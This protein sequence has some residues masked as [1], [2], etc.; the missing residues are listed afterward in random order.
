MTRALV[1]GGTGFVG[2]NL[3][4]TLLRRGD[5]VHLAVRPGHA[6]WRLDGIEKSVAFHDADLRDPDAIS[7]V[8]A[9][10]RPEWV[11]HLATYGAYPDQDDLRTA[12]EV[13]TVGTLNLLEACAAIGFEAFVNTGSSSEYGF[14]DHA[15]T[16]AEALEPNSHYAVSKAMATLVCTHLARARS[17]P[18]TTLRLYSVYGPYEEPGRFIPALVLHGLQASLP[19]LADP[20]T[21]RD[22]VHVEDACNAYLAAA[23]ASPR[24][25]A[26]YNVGSGVQTTLADAVSIAT[27]V[28]GIEERPVWGSLGAR[29]WDTSVWVADA[30]LIRDALGWT[31]TRKF[32]QGLRETAE[33]FRAN[34]ELQAFYRKRLRAPLISSAAGADLR[35]P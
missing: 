23:A 12:L 16:E 34:P 6:R 19:P 9:E 2:A 4:R 28:F 26:V 21:A 7:R 22:F 11:F 29:R 5:E 3:T 1:T 20:A 27:G 10:V 15:P 14:K 30:R 13:N 25:G 35:H 31:A 18:V 33:W 17:L 24:P 8:V 32:E